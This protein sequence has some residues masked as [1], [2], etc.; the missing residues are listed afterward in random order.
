MVAEIEQVVAERFQFEV[1]GH[2]VEFYGR[3]Q[4][5][6]QFVFNAEMQRRGGP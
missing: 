5:C 3:C 1:W 2:L 4:N 6:Q